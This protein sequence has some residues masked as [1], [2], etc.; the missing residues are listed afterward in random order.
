MMSGE[1]AQEVS[2]PNPEQ[3]VCFLSVLSVAL[4]HSECA[5]CRT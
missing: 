4:E 2:R 3:T 5:E 1:L